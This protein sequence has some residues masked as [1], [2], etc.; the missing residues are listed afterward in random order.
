MDRGIAT[1]N[2]LELLKE[3]HYP[4]IVVERRAT[5][6][7]YAQEFTTAKDTFEKIANDADDFHER[8]SA[9]Y[10]KK[11]LTEDASGCFVGVKD[12]SKKNGR[13]IP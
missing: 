13:W 5:E 4:Y 8:S 12:E 11:I 3:K 10:V 6:K 9:V 7:D 2:N 1:K